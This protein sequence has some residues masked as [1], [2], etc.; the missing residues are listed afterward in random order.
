MWRFMAF[1]AVAACSS[2]VA[3]TRAAPS[4]SQ[5]SRMRALEPSEAAAP[6]PSR[7][8]APVLVVLVVDQLASWVLEQRLSSLSPDGAF[9]RLR[10]EGSYAPSLRYEHATSSTAPGHAALFTGLPPRDSG[11]FANERLDDE[12]NEPVS[13]FADAQTRVVLDAVLDAPSSS[14]A[15]LRAD[16]LADALRAQRPKA[17]IWALSLKDRAP[18]FPAEAGDRTPPFGSTSRAGASSPLRRSRERCR[19]G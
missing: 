8:E 13:V 18:P 9:A 4:V 6:A 14:G 5:T 17:R 16:T 12:T 15:L 2:P 19:T 11:V 1:L 3:G 7:A 10:R